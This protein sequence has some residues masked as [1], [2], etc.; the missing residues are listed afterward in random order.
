MQIQ[1]A[2]FYPNDE[3]KI[4]T[5]ELGTPRSDEAIVRLI[6]TGVCQTDLKAAH[7][8]LMPLPAVL[9]HE[10]VGV[11]ERIGSEVTSV[12]PGDRVLVTFDSCGMCPSCASHRPSYCSSFRPLN[13]GGTRLDGSSAVTG[14]SGPLHA[15][16]FGQSS[17]ATHALCRQRNVVRVPDCVP[18]ELL[19]TLA[20]IGCGIQTGAGAILNGLKVVPGMSVAVFG[21]GAVGL[22]A[23]MAAKVAGASTVVAVDIIDDRLALAR[24]VGATD[25][26]N[27]A[28]LDSGKE[29]GRI[30]PRGFDRTLDASGAIPAIEAAM[31][32]LAYGGICGLTANPASGTPARIDVMNLM[33]G[34]RSVRGLIE[35]DS[36]GEA[37]ILRL[38][39]L[40]LNKQMPLERIIK[41]YDFD[42]IHTAFADAAAGRAI[43]PVLR[44]SA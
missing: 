8:H 43:K 37:F 1:A 22:A 44:I 42:E 9:G 5:V 2:V 36:D 19:P 38:V 29:L 23:I 15:H 16:F 10:G 12:S 20:P 17:F 24:E 41:F 7:G 21:A 6:A 25:V 34:G 35:G 40:V 39:D 13:F 31:A 30:S 18:D 3:I 11:V 27:S 28:R 14:K 4:E 26:V 32:C 33:W